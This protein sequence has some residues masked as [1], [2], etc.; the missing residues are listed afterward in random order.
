MEINI[1]ELL[2]C[3]WMKKVLIG[4]ICCVMLIIGFLGT[5]FI[6]N[7]INSMYISNFE[8]EF[9]GVENNLMPDES[10]HQYRDIIS[11][12]ALETIVASSDKFSKIDYETMYYKDGIQILQEKIEIDKVLEDVPGKYTLIVASSYFSNKEQAAQFLLKLVELYTDKIKDSIDSI[13]FGEFKTIINDVVNYDD[14][15]NLLLSQ[16]SSLIQ[17][18]NRLKDSYG[19]VYVEG[20]RISSYV[21]EI[22]TQLKYSYFTQILTEIKNENY[23]N[24]IEIERINLLRDKISLEEQLEI[25]SSIID[26]CYNAIDKIGTASNMQ[27]FDEYNELIVSLIKSNA[28]IKNNIDIIN[29]KLLQS[30]AKSN[31]QLE[32]DLE[33]EEMVSKVS[34]Y[35]VMVEDVQKSV[36]NSRTNS[37]FSS[38]AIV[39]ENGGVSSLIGGILFAILGFV[40]TSGVVLFLYIDK[41]ANNSKVN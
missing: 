7:P 12:D 2:K 37:I 30:N 29:N 1:K 28:N 25:N 5:K 4:I 32:F 38:N 10:V 39:S 36:Y 35:T 6:Y 19:D 9:E 40:C 14:K 24:D 20:K 41:K 17:T 11:V 3:V 13:T 22:E 23:V 27:S 31:E 33:L 26:E 8:L 34:N 16:K 15:V 18:L 21:T